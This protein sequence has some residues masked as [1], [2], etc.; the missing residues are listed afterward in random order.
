M[1]NRV[2]EISPGPSTTPK[3]PDGGLLADQR[4]E[5]RR[6]S[7]HAARRGRSHR[8]QAA[9]D[10]RAPGRQGVRR[11]APA[12]VNQT[13]LYLNPALSQTAAL[14]ARARRRPARVRA[15][16][17]D[18]RDSRRLGGAAR[19]R[20]RRRAGSG[21]SALRQIATGATRSPTSS[22]AGR[23]YCVRHGRRSSALT[24]LLPVRRPVLR[25]PAPL[26]RA[27][28]PPAARRPAGRRR[29]RPGDR[30]DPR[31]AAPGRQGPQA[32]AGRRRGRDARAAVDDAC[33]RELLPIVA[34]LR[35]YAPDFIGGLF[36]GFGG[37]T[38]GYY[39]AN[40]HFIRISLQGARD[41]FAGTLIPSLPGSGFDG[42]RTGLTARCPA[43]P[44]SR[45]S[46]SRTRGSRTRRSATRSR[47]RHRN[48]SPR[49]PRTRDRPWSSPARCSPAARRLATARRAPTTST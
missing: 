19:R 10:R 4:D 23:R 29:Q 43:R 32:G 39:D 37:S 27:A 44:R 45:R 14:G 38:A 42:L 35:V 26:D 24:R 9:E 5:G 28:G 40:G 20:S 7:R 13:L 41:S 17:H 31:A 25:E 12:Q 22:T 3:L 36:D 48:A 15:A 8:S 21:A 47:R 46:T 33:A 2:V 1:T 11:P 18:R 49:R 30:C 6:R 34:G 16:D